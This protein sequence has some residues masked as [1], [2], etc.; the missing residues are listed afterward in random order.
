M[1][2]GLLRV[3]NTSEFDFTCLPCAVWATGY[4]LYG[5]LGNGTYAD[6]P[7]FTNVLNLCVDFAIS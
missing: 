3:F 1:D 5:N 4:G 2:C 7:E 6:L